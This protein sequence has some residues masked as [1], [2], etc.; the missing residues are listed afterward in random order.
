[1]SV[2]VHPADRVEVDLHRTLVLG[3]FGLWI[4]PEELLATA[5]T[6]EIG[7]RSL[8][9]LSDTGLLVNTAM[10]AALGWW[11]P[12]LVPLR[13]VHQ[14]TRSGSVDWDLLARWCR[15]WRLTAILDRAFS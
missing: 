9:R 7:G 14:V 13:D 5:T 11:P 2:H 12:R 15:A 8:A 3:P 1:A 10:H 6:F 4:N